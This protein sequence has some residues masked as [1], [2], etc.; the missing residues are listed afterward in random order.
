MQ[1][2]D[3]GEQASCRAGN[4]G[5]HRYGRAPQGFAEERGTVTELGHV[6]GTKSSQIGM[7]QDK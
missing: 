2:N 5:P 7:R 6:R 4:G 1:N 3:I